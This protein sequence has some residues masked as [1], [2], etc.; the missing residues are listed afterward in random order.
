LNIVFAGTPQFT[1]PCLDALAQS[2]HKLT[3]VYTQPDRPAG[4]GHKLQP[5]PVK[6][7]AKAHE[8]PVYQPLN[9]KTQESIDTLAALAPDI[10]IVIAYGLILPRTVLTI[11]RYGCVNAHASLLPHWRGASPIQQ[12]IL[13]HNPSS[14]M[15]LMQMDEGMDTGAILATA[16]CLIDSQDTAG[17][18]HDKLAQLTP[19][20][21]LTLLDD[22]ASGHATPKAQDNQLAS[23]APKIKKEDAAIRWQQPAIAI[24][25]Q[26]RAFNPWP[27]AYTHADDVTIRIHKARVLN[28]VSNAEP[29]TIMT[30]DKEGIHVATGQQTLL[31]EQLQF[32]GGK[33]ISVSDWLN[34]KHL[35]LHVHQVLT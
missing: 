26:I 15:T 7:W 8:I 22:I 19:P 14:G 33:S 20:L 9:F 30:I 13:H 35:Q 1:L 23:Y 24:D 2:K 28:Q 3:A 18:L 10:M 27:I 25:C 29:G 16:S 11:P 34:A 32:A 21:L 12:A 31:I 17:T 4:R 5:S 6:V